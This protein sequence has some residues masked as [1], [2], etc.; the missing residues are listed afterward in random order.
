M[1]LSTCLPGHSFKYFRVFLRFPALIFF[2][3]RLLQEG[4]PVLH[5]LRNGKCE[6]DGFTWRASTQYKM[7]KYCGAAGSISTF[8]VKLRNVARIPLALYFSFSMVS[9]AYRVFVK[10][11]YLFSGLYSLRCTL[12]RFYIF[13]KRFHMSGS[14]SSLKTSCRPTPL[15]SY[16]ASSPSPHLFLPCSIL[17]TPK[18]LS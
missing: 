16:S 14:S 15:Q 13:H 17:I 11:F 9:N 4:R 12:N 1:C 18:C 2:L 8:N 10:L 5:C 3:P 6:A 7:R